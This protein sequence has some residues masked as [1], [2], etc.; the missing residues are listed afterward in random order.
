MP[1]AEVADDRAEAEELRHRHR[2]HGGGEVDEQ[3]R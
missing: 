2:D 1:G 3:A